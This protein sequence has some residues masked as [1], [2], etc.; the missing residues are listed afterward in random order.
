[1]YANTV[2]RPIVGSLYRKIM[3]KYSQIIGTDPRYLALAFLEIFCYT[4]LESKEAKI[5]A[6]G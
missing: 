2:L 6:R 3:D 4:C 1:M 5:H